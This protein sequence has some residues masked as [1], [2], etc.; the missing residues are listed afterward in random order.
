MQVF[1]ADVIGNGLIVVNLP[2]MWRL[3]GPYFA[4]EPFPILSQVTI[5]G[6]TFTLT[7]GLFGM[8]L[9]PKIGYHSQ[10][11]I[12]RPFASRSFYAAK[13]ND[14]MQTKFERPLIYYNLTNVLPSQSTAQAF[15]SDGILFFGLTSQIAI[16]CWNQFQD[17]IPENIV[18]IINPSVC[19]CLINC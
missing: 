13:M 2:Y 9:S 1:I 17:M 10:Y 7:D 18:R 4:P 16:G 6:E 19:N 12:F 8:A 3:D 14:I 15:S 5:A 11:L